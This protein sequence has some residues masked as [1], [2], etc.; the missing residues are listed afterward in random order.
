VLTL[1]LLTYE[2]WSDIFTRLGPGEVYATLGVALYLEGLARIAPS[3]RGTA[4]RGWSVQGGWA[5]LGLGAWL[6]MGSKEN[7]LL[8]LLPL[9]GVTILLWRRRG[10]GRAGVATVIVLTLYGALIT[11]AVAVSVLRRGVDVYLAPV[12]GG[13]RLGLVWPGVQRAVEPLNG[14]HAALGVIVVLVVA[15]RGPARAQWLLRPALRGGLL[16]GGLAALFVSQFVFYNGAW[17]QT[18]GAPRYDFPGVL[19][20]PLLLI[21]G[22]VAGLAMLRRLRVPGPLV[23]VVRAGLVALLLGLTL[24]AGWGPLREASAANA[25]ATREWTAR[26]DRIAARLRHEPTHP[27]LVVSHDIGD[28]EPIFAI[29]RFFAAMRV[30]NPLFL[31]IPVYR[32]DTAWTEVLART[33]RDAAL[34]GAAGYRPFEELPETVLPLAIGLSGAP[35]PPYEDVGSLWPMPGVGPR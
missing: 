15:A 28:Y 23:R 30:T 17:P 16:A 34:F 22:A 7:F 25:A 24:A 35:P 9:W 2:F 11:S 14:W 6:A 20:R 5:M 4:P 21:T 27:V 8:L 13:G 29:P 12:T 26:L 18:P 33:L 19:A 32:T 31:A 10:L 3:V 1:Y